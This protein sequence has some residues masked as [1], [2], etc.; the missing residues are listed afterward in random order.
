MKAR[1]VGCT[2]FAVM[3]L[4]AGISW[5]AVAAPAPAPAQE[6]DGA[7]STPA[8]SPAAYADLV[9][10]A[11]TPCRIMDTRLAQGGAGPWLAGSSNQVKIG[12][13]A[14]GYA[15]GPGAQGGSPTSCGLD[16]L[17]GPGEVAAILAAVSTLNQAAPGFLSFYPESTATPTSVSMRY[18]A[19][20]TQVAFVLIPTNLVGTVSAF[21]NTNATTDVIVDIVGYYSA[22]AADGVTNVATGAGLTGGP[23]T[24]TGTIGLAATNL[25]PTTACATNQI[26]KWSGS[27]WAC[28]ADATG[29][30]V[31]GVTASAPLA[32]SGGTAPN[33]TLT[34]PLPVAN[35]GTGQVSLAGNG[36]VIGQGTSAVASAVGAAGQVLAGTAGAPVFTAS[37]SI[38]GNL[39]LV[40]STSSTGLIYKGAFPFIHN[41]GAQNLFMGIFSGNFTMTG[42]Q[43]TVVGNFSLTSNTTGFDN[44]ATGQSSLGSNTTG[45]GNTANGRSALALNTTGAN[46]TASGRNSLFS[47]TSGGFNTAL[48]HGALSSNT[49]GG[50]NTAAGGNAL[51]NNIT[52]TNNTAS[53]TSAMQNNSDGNQ[54]SAY[55]S[56]ALAFNTVGN[57]NTASGFFALTGNTTGINNTGDGRSAMA[58]NT[59]GGNN[60]GSGFQ[61]LAFNTTGSNNIALGA[62]AG[63]QLTTGS[64]NIA[65]G[66][67][68]GAAE[69]NTTRIGDSNQ[70][71]TFISGIRG[72]STGSASGVTVLIDVNGQLG[73][74]SSSRRFKDDID[75][76]SVA[77]SALMK[78][79]PVTFHYKS[80]KSL[81]GRTLQYG[82][83]AEEVADI[84]PGLVAHSADGQVETVLYQFLP[85]MLL[86]EYQKQQRT[87]EAQKAEIAT[88]RQI[89]ADVRRDHRLQSARMDALEQRSI[90]QAAYMAK[91]LDQMRRPGATSAS[92]AWTH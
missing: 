41:F 73:T 39:T 78:L 61:A 65:I 22:S 21:G 18:Q 66:H 58:N 74:V 30:T 53:G 12:P 14:T 64:F 50:S 77:S 25:L 34:S 92:L 68:G 29:G 52:G 46:N 24:S 59:T 28:A 85:S 23:I 43:N 8:T 36:V 16:A 90:E 10:T 47:N 38:S 27:A 19:G 1:N 20:F 13:Y 48:G 37:P 82:L 79:R 67:P 35:G 54:N 57:G 87:I 3:G 40:D 70:T 17:A 51:L 75:D 45:S 63:V 26:P 11:L 89:L 62:N 7:K 76:M 42:G 6:R 31:T 72:V 60:T 9:F 83:I 80:D 49:T 69:G 56:G 55:G 5:N 88:Q 44:T 15:S 32:S 2:V 86:N 33:I 84:Y 71:R 91:L 81:S 4:A